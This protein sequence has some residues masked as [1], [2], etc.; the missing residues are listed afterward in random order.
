MRRDFRLRRRWER[1]LMARDVPI[2]DVAVILSIPSALL[3]ADLAG[4]RINDDA[5]PFGELDAAAARR[6][7][8]T[9][10]TAAKVRRMADLRYTWPRIAE[11]LELDPE[12]V[13][14]FLRRIRPV[15]PDRAN[16]SDLV[17]ARDATKIAAA[18]RAARR[19]RERRERR[20]G[21]T[22]QGTTAVQ[23]WT[24]ADRVAS[25]RAEAAA[26]AALQ[27]AVREGR[28][29][30]AAV[31]DLAAGLHFAEPRRREL[32][33]AAIWTGD[34]TWHHGAPKLDAEQVA[35]IREL[36]RAGWSTGKLARRFA[37]T[38]ATICY[39]LSGRT[40]HAAPC[41]APLIML[42]S[43]GE[44]S[45]ISAEKPRL[46]ITAPWQEAP[47]DSQ[48]GGLTHGRKTAPADKVRK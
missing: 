24:Y 41:P 7:S 20:R 16:R 17:R 40:S 3:E 33:A 9:G 34:E 35:E 29:S 27:T 13:R 32:P 12:R 26:L 30:A 8:L 37:V 44:K 19:A 47:V 22:P 23:G 18:R 43:N 2:A 5:W 15:R 14:D 21:L 38:R 4:A 39:A 36:R 1:W 25:G 31:L 45:R 10:R 46:I 11:L 6:R 42:P 48:S 28:L